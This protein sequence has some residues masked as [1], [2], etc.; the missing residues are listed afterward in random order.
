MNS[1]EEILNIIFKKKEFIKYEVDD[2]GIVTIY[3]KQ[4]H[5][6]QRFF[7]RLKFRIPMYK[8]IT[9]DEY[10]SEV[11][12]NIDGK[13]NVKEIGEDLQRKYGENVYPLYERLLIFLNHI[14]IN[15]N[16]IEKVHLS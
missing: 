1:N 15:C 10:S 16:Y 4:D 7:R 11:F 3:E 2:K 13:K 5:I 8:S 14:Y 6:I 9:F 12:I